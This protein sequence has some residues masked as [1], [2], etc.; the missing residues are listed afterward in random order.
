MR[1]GMVSS[2]SSH[3]SSPWP[4]LLIF[5][6]WEMIDAWNRARLPLAHALF[7]SHWV[8]QWCSGSFLWDK[9]ER[10]RR[11]GF[12]GLLTFLF[13]IVIGATLLQPN[14]GLPKTYSNFNCVQL[15]S[16]ETV[17]WS[18]ILFTMLLFGLRPAQTNKQTENTI[19]FSVTCIRIKRVCPTSNVIKYAI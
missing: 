14:K 11:S 15:L 19:Y 5:N 16:H 13:V 18:K 1:W 3:W 6:R 2:S 8:R 9:W 10:V 12:S 7:T 17:P 4:A